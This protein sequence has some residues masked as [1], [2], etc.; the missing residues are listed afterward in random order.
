MRSSAKNNPSLYANRIRRRCGFTLVELLVVIAIIGILVALLL[1]AVQA[2]REAA[3]R[4]ECKNQLKQLGLGAMNHESA[5]GH[6][7]TG[8]WGW[9]WTGDP[10]RGYGLDQPGGWYYNVLGYIEQNAIRQLGSDGN[11]GVVTQQQKDGTLPA[12]QAGIAWFMCPSRRGDSVYPLEQSS[13]YLTLDGPPGV[14]GR[15]DYAANGGDRFNSNRLSTTGPNLGPGDTVIPPSSTSWGNHMRAKGISI[16]GRTS[17]VE[18]GTGVVLQYSLIKLPQVADGTSNTIFLG[19][20]FIPS[21][22]YDTG[23]SGDF[24]QGNDQG[25]NQ[26]WDIDNI[27]WTLA[28]PR[29][30]SQW[31]TD[32]N[33]NRLPDSPGDGWLRYRVFGSAHPAGGN[34]TFVDGSVHTIPYDVDEQ[35]FK[36]LGHRDDGQIVDSSDL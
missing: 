36:Y 18:G 33:G 4:A 17:T 19:E 10:D 8:G 16:G 11:P 9:K 34:F 7:P 32:N 25:W 22:Q 2:A 12:V 35:V 27:R 14:V 26:G 29:A 13:G 24:N 23:D 15:N 21:D 20:K 5:Q 6:L 30:D 31:F 3:R 1:P 28:A